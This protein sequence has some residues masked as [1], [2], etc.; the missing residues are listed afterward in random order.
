MSDGQQTTSKQWP[1][2]QAYSLAAICLLVGI[3][4][5]YLGGGRANAPTNTVAPAS[6]ASTES[7]V[8]PGHSA[9]P[10]LPEGASTQP[11]MPGGASGGAAQRAMRQPTPEEMKRMVAKAVAPL[12]EQLKQNPKDAGLHSKIGADYVR[13]SQFADAVPYF[14]KASQLK[15]SA[16][17]FTSLASAQAYSGKPDA[18]ID[19]LNHALKLDPTSADALFNLGMLKWRAKGDNKGAIAC[20]EKLL[21]T[22]PNHPKLDVVRQLIA[23]V[24]GS[25]GA[26]AASG[27][28]AAATAAT[29]ATATDR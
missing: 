19:N 26:E 7:Q 10:Q 6:V 12:L 23:H 18:A 2:I 8:P 11:Q 22:N 27:A 25:K 24:N 1:S 28:P 14:E 21:K 20:W 3:A 17:A 5:G 9:M 13:A 15:P 4:F 29:S 16:E